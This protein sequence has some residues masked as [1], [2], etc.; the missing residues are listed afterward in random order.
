[1]NDKIAKR[2]IEKMTTTDTKSTYASLKSKEEELLAQLEELRE[3]IANAEKDIIPEKLNTALQYL[4]DVDEMTHG[5]YRCT[6]EVY[7]ESCEE[8][9][10]IDIDL[11]DI[12]SAL[13]QIR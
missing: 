1:M 12:I 9:I 10:E 4:T 3:E 13:Q 5:H 2:M 8:N 11:A 6:I 7:C